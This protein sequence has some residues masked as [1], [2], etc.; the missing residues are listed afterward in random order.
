MRGFGPSNSAIRNIIGSNMQFESF[1]RKF[2][3]KWWAGEKLDRTIAV[4]L[5]TEL[6]K[7]E[8]HTPRPVVGGA[9]DGQGIVYFIKPQD[10]TRFISNHRNSLKEL[11][12][13]N[14]AFD[15]GVMEKHCDTDFTH[16]VM[17]NKIIDTAILYRLIYIAT[18]GMC[19]RRYN[20]DLCSHELLGTSLNKNSDIRLTFDQY[21]DK[22]IKEISPQH[23]KYLAEDCIATYL[24]AKKLIKKVDDLPTS[25]N[26]SHQIQLMGDLALNKIRKRGIGVDVD[27][28]NNLRLDL[29]REMDKNSNIMATY[30]LIRGEKGFQSKYEKVI[31]FIGIDLP[32][33]GKTGK[34][35]MK[36]EH[37]E[38]Y[39]GNHFVDALLEYL[40][41]EK[42]RSFLNELT[43]ERV[44]PIYDSIKNTL[45]T[46]CRKPNIQNPPRKGGI[47][48]S[49]VPSSGN[50][51]IDIDYASIE[52]YAL[53][54]V[55]K[56]YYGE[57]ILFDKLSAGNDVH[58]YAASEIF[59]KSEAE[60]TSHERQI[61]KICNY[62]LAANMGAETFRK[63]MAKQGVELE[64]EE[65]KRIKKA[66][67]AAFPEIQQ[68]WRRGYNRTTFVSKTGFVR[69]NCTYTQY[70]NSHFQSLVAEGC[71]IMLY[72][73]EKE[74]YR[75]VAFIHDEIVIEHPEASAK[76][77]MPKIQKI[78]EE[79]MQKLIPTLKIKTDGKITTR[80]N[81]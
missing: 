46:G 76:E 71:K 38:P 47:R 22:D 4:D 41:L 9:Y 65:T 55:L 74:G 29:T 35:S 68:F 43:E 51:F 15:T 14:A 10:L 81:K 25:N 33:T 58:I 54:H 34:L 17:G 62:G 45:R 13:H 40:E 24:V 19:P 6:I 73:L 59:S 12:F 78:M 31:E 63:H 28:V 2:T 44:Y 52:L 57:S 49:F 27:Y 79:A 26:L 67:A 3:A 69:A 80:F 11:Y 1:N 64:L 30:G 32:R 18:T 42:R 60:V 16:L 23:L 8:S 21:L 66:W 72:F 48:E 50:V 75:T 20:L 70:L 39:K 37:L 53:A 7:S 77:A 5:E 61:A 56:S 36:A